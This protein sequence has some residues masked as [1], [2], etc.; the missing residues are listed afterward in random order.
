MQF[1]ARHS[2]WRHCGRLAVL[3]AAGA[4]LASVTL[5]PTAGATT[6]P[7]MPALPSSSPPPAAQLGSPGSLS[8]Q[9]SAWSSFFASQAAK[10][11]TSATK[12]ATGQFEAQWAAT[13]QQVARAQVPLPPAALPSLSQAEAGLRG[14]SV[15]A[16]AP[17]PE[18]AP[19][20]LAMP[21]PPPPTGGTAGLWAQVF[22][23]A[24]SLGGTAPA[25]GSLQLNPTYAAPATA[26]KAY[27]A[28][29]GCSPTELASGAACSPFLATPSE[30]SGATAA[31][32]ANIPGIDTQLKAVAAGIAATDK[33]MKVGVSGIATT[34]C[35]NA[36]MANVW[37]G[38]ASMMS[39]GTYGGSCSAA[40]P[41][42][43]KGN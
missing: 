18:L 43:T 8:P 19:P 35:T 7:P 21:S 11:V 23:A 40:T 1:V 12:T 33:Q 39:G 37:A 42:F 20:T 25:V 6:L 16:V 2:S 32:A 31:A 22:G 26:D 24:P 17:L 28:H 13:E 27:F 5:A 9:I 30:L 3:A 34:Q 41:H 10:V 14:A 38:L 29:I 4:G 15:V 36:A